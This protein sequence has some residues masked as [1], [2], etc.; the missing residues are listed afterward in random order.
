MRLNQ[1]TVMVSDVA[2]AIDFYQRLGLR[3][4][5]KSP[6]Y[7]RFVCPDGGST[8]SVHVAEKHETFVPSSATIYFEC[9]DL[10]QRVEQLTANSIAFDSMP[11]DQPWL[12]R[13][14]R[15]RDPDDN[16]ICMYY[17]GENRLNP[18]WVIK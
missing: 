7:A 10:D 13:E 15:L 14:A 17:A 12:W 6:H 11:T 4:I 16:P 5:V 3:L 2:R 9:D 18:P 1:V 8:F